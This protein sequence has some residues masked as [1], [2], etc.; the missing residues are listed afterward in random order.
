MR[1]VWDVTDDSVADRV[2]DV[3]RKII[4]V[5]ERGCLV[6]YVNDVSGNMTES[7]ST[8]VG[9]NYCVDVMKCESGEGVCWSYSSNSRR[10]S[11]DDYRLRSLPMLEQIL[12]IG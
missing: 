5:S 2:V 11:D 8:D 7:K 4:T 10:G 3:C 6:T 12:L 9:L 1:G